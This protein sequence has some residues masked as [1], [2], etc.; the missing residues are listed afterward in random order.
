MFA[1]SFLG[2]IVAGMALAEG[3]KPQATRGPATLKEVMTLV[4]DPSA[5]GIF[6]VGSQAPK[7]DADWKTL[8]GQALTLMEIANTLTAPNRTPNQVKDKQEWTKFAKALQTE[9][10]KAFALSMAKDVK[11]LGDLSDPLYQTCADCH[12][13]YLPKR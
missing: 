9:S 10:R 12:E 11:A 3:S 6:Q 2:V 4:V 7:N 1:V 5:N 8:Q 13:K